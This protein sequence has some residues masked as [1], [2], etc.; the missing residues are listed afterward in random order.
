[1]F[2]A[3]QQEKATAALVGDAQAVA[4]R[5][6]SAKKH[7]VDS[8]AATAW[9][10]AIVLQS[11]GKDVHTIASWPHQAV[12]RFV[13]ADHTR[14]AVLRKKR[15]YDLSDGLAVW[16]HTARAVAEPRILPPVREIWQMI[17]NAG[18]NAEG[19]A[20][21]LVAEAGLSALPVRQAPLGFAPD[22]ATGG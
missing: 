6:A 20:G 7:V 2:N 9:F 5:L 19:M 14:I 8:H 16:L 17:L 18:P 21:D 22:D 10:W 3:W 15:D 13:A 1:M 12:T 11:E 4:D